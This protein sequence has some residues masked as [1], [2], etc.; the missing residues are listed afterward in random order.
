MLSLL[1]FLVMAVAAL[2]EKVFLRGPNHIPSRHRPTR[3]KRH[4]DDLERL[5]GRRLP[6]TAKAAAGL[7]L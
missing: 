5:T 1:R 7:Q 2:A 6:E 4:Q 3:F